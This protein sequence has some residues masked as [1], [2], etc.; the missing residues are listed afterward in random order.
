MKDLIEALQILLKYGDARNPFYCDHDVLTV[1]CVT[2][3][4]VTEEDK[5]RL[6]KLGFFI[7]EEYGESYFK[8][9][10]YGS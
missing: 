9:F 4:I 7:S 1:Q 3:D 10:R 6:D 5:E 8:S 2:P